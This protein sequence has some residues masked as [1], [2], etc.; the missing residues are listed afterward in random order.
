ME[1]GGR[2]EI[3][4]LFFGLVNKI[5][6]IHYLYLLSTTHNDF[7]NADPSRMLDACHI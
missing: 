7:E 5:F 1:W 4:Y 3:W 6:R 2:E